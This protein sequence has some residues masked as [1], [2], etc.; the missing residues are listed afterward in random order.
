[1]RD[2]ENGLLVPC[3]D[4]VRLADAITYLL[5]HPSVAARMGSIG[6]ELAKNYSWR[7]VVGEVERLYRS[8]TRLENFDLHSWN[9]FS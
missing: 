7:A 8:L 9:G 4:E 2:G 6:R 1:M 5:S 3:R